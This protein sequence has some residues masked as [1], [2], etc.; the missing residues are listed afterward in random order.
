MEEQIKLSLN[1]PIKA[2]VHLK[3]KHFLNGDISIHD[4]PDMI[5]VVSPARKKVFA[6]PKKLNDHVYN[7]QKRLF[8]YLSDH[9]V[10]NPQTIRMG[11]LF[12]SLEAR[13]YDPY[14]PEINA[15]EVVIYAISKF[16]RLEE[17]YYQ[18]IEY[19]ENEIEKE[20]L[21]PDDEDSTKH[22]EVPHEID[23]VSQTYLNA[24]TNSYRYG[25]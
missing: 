3:A 14:K 21:E 16:F 19:Y 22:G 6:M 13:I 24:A 4:H 5:I 2:V 9:G 1:S 17:P 12:F 11:N 23:N 18:S 8:D 15:F 25:Y 7:S 20:L 10:V